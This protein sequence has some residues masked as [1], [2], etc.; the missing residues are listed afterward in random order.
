VRWKQYLSQNFVQFAQSWGGNRPD[1][2][3]PPE[4]PVGRGLKLV[5][6]FAVLGSIETQD[7]FFFLNP[8]RNEHV[9]KFED[10]EG[11]NGGES[12]H[13]YNRQDLLANLGEIAGNQAVRARRVNGL[14]AE[15][16]GRDRAP[17]TAN[18]VAGENIEGVVNLDNAFELNGPVAEDTGE[19]P[20]QD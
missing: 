16:T 2:D 1:T 19:E 13:G 6:R 10:A 8:Q 9:D 5:S 20:Y 7:F 15:D 3:R 11:H 17:D 12:D 18:A 4:N 14:L